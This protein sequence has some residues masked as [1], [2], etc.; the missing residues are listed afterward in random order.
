ML[1]LLRRKAQSPF[2]QATV[3]IIAL[4]FIFWGVGTNNQGSDTSIATVNDEPIT[5]QQYQ[6]AYNR[7]VN[8]LSE[9]FGGSIPKGLLES[10]N[11]EEQVLDQLINGA[12]LRQAATEMGLTISNGEVSEKVRR[13]EA[14]KSNDSFD[15]AQYEAI[16]SASRITPATFEDSMRADL[17]T[18]KVMNHV[19][20]FAKNNPVAIQERLR[21]E[22]DEINLEYVV[23]RADSF[24]KS[25][26]VTDEAL[27]AYYEERK[28]QYKTDPQVQLKY[29]GFSFDD[30]QETDITDDRVQQ[31]YQQNMQNYIVPEKR[32]VRHI[33]IKTGQDDSAE[34]LAAK[35]QQAED[36][37]ARAKEEGADFAELARQYSEGPSAP[38][39]GD[40]G[41]FSRGK[42]V[43]SF[44]NAVFAMQAEGVFADVVQ[45]PFGFHVIKVDSVEAERVRPV[46]EVKDEIIVAVVK[47]DASTAAWKAAN[48]AYEEIILAGSLD[49]YAATAEVTVHETDFFERATPPPGSP[50]LRDVS[51]LNAAFSLNK[52]ELSSLLDTGA[53]YAIIYALDRR[54]SK[55]APFDSVREDVTRDYT[56]S[57]A[58]ELAAEAAENFLAEVSAAPADESG[59]IAAIEKLD[60][61]KMAETGFMSRSNAGKTASEKQLPVAIINKGFELSVQQPYPDVP[62]KSG[63][64]SIVYR[65]KESRIADEILVAEKEDAFAA[66]QL[67]KGKSALV[68]AWLEYLKQKAEIT[69]RKEYL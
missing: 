20:N 28:E 25:V 40:L 11:V 50:F 66:Q 61:I 35:R 15:M 62:A 17:L 49:K 45:T 37:L 44:D 29:L 7:T 26:E 9:Q 59:W 51:F 1:G 57:Q 33:L 19:G 46:D 13:M 4:V 60:D 14:F 23:F 24:K 12:L 65:L 5:Y 58:I 69:T 42:M 8:Q 39:G 3:L 38:K 41:S 68:Q 52:G 36:I 48:K 55:T 53:G 10:M 27:Q 21:F 16:L 32:S 18:S 63:A 30:F 34:V 64:L 54:E 67:E 56:N 2:I 22:N 6:Q 47:Q 43:A 31:Y